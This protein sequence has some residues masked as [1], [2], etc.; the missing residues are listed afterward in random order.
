MKKKIFFLLTFFIYSSS[1]YSHCNEIYHSIQ[2]EK[3]SSKSLNRNM[4]SGSYSNFVVAS[5]NDYSTKIGYDILNMGGTVADAAVAIQLTL[6]LVEP[7]SSGL[8]GG[9]FLTYFD[10]KT[11]KVISFEGREK[12]PKN[13]KS[14]IFLKNDGSPKKF[15]DAVIGGSSVGVPS[16]LKTLYTFHK[17]Y[18][19][20]EWKDVIR[21]V[22]NFSSNG[23]I[24]S[25][26]LINALE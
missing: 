12:A 20:L 17:L 24:P 25:N 21:P 4:K 23:F 16:A 6:G 11:S 3:S 1:N 9:L 8:G 22:I 2:P 10:R 26:R 7:Q 18:G 14:N 19:V 5:A 13:L 15:F